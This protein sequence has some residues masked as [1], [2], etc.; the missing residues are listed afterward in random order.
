MKGYLSFCFS[1]L[2]RCKRDAL[3]T[4]LTAQQIFKNGKMPNFKFN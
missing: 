1:G 3:P 2:G 4:E